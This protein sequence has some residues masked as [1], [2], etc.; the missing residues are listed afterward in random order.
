MGGLPGGGEVP[1]QQVGDGRGL[2]DRDQV[3]G[4][5]DDRETGVGNAGDQGSGLG[6]AG[7]L[8]VGA[9]ED[10]G[11][12]AD[13]AEF[14]AH[15]ER[16]EGLAGGDVAAG[17]GGPHHLHGP[18]GDRGLGC[19]V[20]AGEPALRGAAGDGVEPVGAHDHAALAELV[21]GAEAGRG[22][23]Q[24]EGGEALGVAQGEF[25]ADGAAERTACVPEAL[26][27]ESVEGGQQARGEFGDGPR[28]V[29]RGATV[30]GQVET[31][32]PPLLGQFGHLAV[33]H[34]PCGTQ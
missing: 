4:A 32:D 3:G 25:D 26:H 31:E 22:G 8:V 14:T 16:G 27:A 5:G 12:H 21:G 28:R 10:Q 29:G 18:L 20:P 19:R 6:G 11:G 13:P 24:R 17:V 9:D 2:L 7:D 30:S 23:D 1:Y 34:V 33:P 15:V